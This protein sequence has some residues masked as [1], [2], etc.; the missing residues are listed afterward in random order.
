MVARH[1]CLP[2][3]LPPV[4]AF[5]L[6]FSG[7]G[8][9]ALRVHR[10]VPP[11]PSQTGGLIAETRGGRRAH[12]ASRGLGHYG[13]YRASSLRLCHCTARWS[14]SP[15]QAARGV[16]L[17]RAGTTTTTTNPAPCPVQYGRHSRQKMLARVETPVTNAPGMPSC[18]RH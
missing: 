4:R 18:Q 15:A 13:W 8:A 17:S 16:V 9:I 2:M 10:T 1:P 14:P 7:V 5:Q 11:P 12:G 6:V 3:P